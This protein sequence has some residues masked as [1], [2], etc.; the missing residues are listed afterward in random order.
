[1]RRAAV[2]VFSGLFDGIKS[3]ESGIT[4]SSEDHVS[5][6]AN[7]SQRNLFAFAGIVP[8]RVGDAD[9]ILNDLDVWVSCFRALF[10]PA[11][12]SMDQ[13]DIHAANET[14]LAGL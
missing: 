3:A 5:A 2:R 13:A 12:E 6:F 7:L 1:M 11:F 8:R 14:Q 10:V 4:G 9:V